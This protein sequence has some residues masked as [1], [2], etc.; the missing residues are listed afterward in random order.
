MLS[1]A[2]DNTTSPNIGGTDAWAVPHLK[3]FWG[4]R[5]PSPP[6]SPPLVALVDF[7]KSHRESKSLAACLPACLSARRSVSPSVCLSVCPSICLSVC[8]FA[9]LYVCLYVYQSVCC[10]PVCL[11]ACVSVRLPVRLSVDW[12]CSSFP[13]ILRNL[14]EAI[15]SLGMD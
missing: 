6:R 14:S 3:F 8:L 11:S 7:N 2:S 5:P 4:D 9:C 15:I 12:F 1:R 10:L 13:V